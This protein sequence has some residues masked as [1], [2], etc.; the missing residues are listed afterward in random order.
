ME[1]SFYIIKPHSLIFREI[2]REMIEGVG[3]IITDYKKVVLPYWALEIVYSDMREN[4]RS[5]IFQAYSDVTVEA[6]LVSG[7]NAISTLLQIAGT[8]LDPADCAPESIRFKFGER[9]PIMINGIKYYKNV[10]HR[11]RDMMEAEK[12][13]RVFH[14]L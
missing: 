10:I 4:Y 12:D 6:G 9:E 11:S 14:M 2:I 7:K 1:T 13:T 5:A 3:L 8:E